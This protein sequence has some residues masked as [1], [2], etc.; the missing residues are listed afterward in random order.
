MLAY[1]IYLLLP[2]DNSSQYAYAMQL[3]QDDS[4]V[5]AGPPGGD[6]GDWNNATSGGGGRTAGSE[7]E[8]I[9]IELADVEA[10]IV[11]EKL[12]ETLKE[13]DRVDNKEKERTE[14]I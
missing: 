4:E 5:G 12:E 3:P 6:D 10:D 8:E 7:V 2:D 1:I 9:E 13:D 11:L 14:Q